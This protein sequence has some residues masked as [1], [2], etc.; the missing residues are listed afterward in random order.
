M[1][2]QI[3]RELYLFF[4]FVTKIMY[5]KQCASIVGP[6]EKAKSKV[7]YKTSTVILLIAL[8]TAFVANAMSP[9]SEQVNVPTVSEISH[10]AELIKLSEEL[11]TEKKVNEELINKHA[12]A[13]ERASILNQKY[14]AAEERYE[15]RAN[16]LNIKLANEKSK[17]DA[18]LSRLEVLEDKIDTKESYQASVPENNNNDDVFNDIMEMY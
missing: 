17:V 16:E 9:D 5:P 4:I 13:L 1:L 10:S 7:S 14:L 3:K 15:N 18:L 11:A 6:V 12:V 8:L 2:N